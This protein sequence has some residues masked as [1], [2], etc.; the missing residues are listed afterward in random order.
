MANIESHIKS[1]L[2]FERD[3][4]KVVPISSPRSL[5]ACLRSGYDPNELMP[6]QVTPSIWRLF[7]FMR[8]IERTKVYFSSFRRRRVQFY[9][10]IRY[11]TIN[12]GK[13]LTPLAEHR[14]LEILY[15]TLNITSSPFERQVNKSV[16]GKGRI[17]RT[18][19]DPAQFLRASPE[20]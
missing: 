15:G 16:R 17:A 2:N 13:V 4:G 18:H 6:R 3:D 19:R 1:I 11:S 20:R 5:E 7:H 14:A 12:Y 10:I 8:G 9:H